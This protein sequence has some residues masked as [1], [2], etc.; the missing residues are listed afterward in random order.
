MDVLTSWSLPLFGALD[1]CYWAC[2]LKPA[3]RIR[4]ILVWIRILRSV[5]LTNGSFKTATK[6][7]FFQSFFAY[8]FVKLPLHNFSKIKSHKKVA[9][10]YG[11]NQWFSYYSC[12][13]IEGSGSVPLAN[14]SSP[15]PF[16]EV[17]LYRI[18][19]RY[20]STHSSNTF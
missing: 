8:Y 9:K 7:Y 1:L 19:Y 5:P 6:N 12:L 15:D 14:G 17:K 2:K 20:L 18:M 10:Q 16:R 11:R 13:M 4:D 3:L